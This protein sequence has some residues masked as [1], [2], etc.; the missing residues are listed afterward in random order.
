MGLRFLKAQGNFCSTWR[1]LCKVTQSISTLHTASVLCGQARR[2]PL[3]LL[4]HHQDFRDIL[5]TWLFTS[6]SLDYLKGMHAVSSTC[7]MIPSAH[8]E[9]H[10]FFNFY[11]LRSGCSF[12]FLHAFSLLLFQKGRGEEPFSKLM[13]NTVIS[14]ICSE[15]EGNRLGLFY[16]RRMWIN[17]QKKSRPGLLFQRPINNLSIY[18]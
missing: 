11:H 13:M 18:F 3:H 9:V 5:L 12:M 2:H 15:N 16:I 7:A 17:L 4:Y 1:N 6:A 8:W 14:D 10:I